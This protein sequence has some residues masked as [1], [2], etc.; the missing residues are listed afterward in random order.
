MIEMGYT[1]ESVK[2]YLSLFDEVASDVSGV[3]YLKEKA[4]RLSER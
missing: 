1:R 2:T 4:W 3:R